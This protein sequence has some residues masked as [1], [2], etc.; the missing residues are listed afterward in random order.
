M[1]RTQTKQRVIKKAEIFISTK[2]SVLRPKQKIRENSGHQWREFRINQVIHRGK[3]NFMT[4]QERI[5]AKEC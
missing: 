2:K 5:N 3:E 4:D 1:Q